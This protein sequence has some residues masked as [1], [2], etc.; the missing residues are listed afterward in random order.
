MKK[1]RRMA[2]DATCRTA[3]GMYILKNARLDYGRP[4]VRKIM[5]KWGTP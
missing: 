1:V 5:K 3:E 4:H 2:Q